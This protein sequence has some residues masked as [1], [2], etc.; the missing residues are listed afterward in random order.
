[1]A[2]AYRSMKGLQCIQFKL[3]SKSTGK[4]MQHGVMLGLSCT[5]ECRQHYKDGPRKIV[6]GT[7]ADK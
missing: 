2:E 1:V 6:G 4:G 5:G 7:G 3:L